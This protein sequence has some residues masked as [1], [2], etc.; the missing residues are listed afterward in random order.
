MSLK[1]AYVVPNVFQ[2][3]CILERMLALVTMIVTS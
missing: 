3:A 1:S 2:N